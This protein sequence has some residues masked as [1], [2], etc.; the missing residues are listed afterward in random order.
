MKTVAILITVAA[1]LL[2]VGNLVAFYLKEI[3]GL[4]L[5]LNL[6]SSLCVFALGVLALRRHS[7]T[8]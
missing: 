2:I 8:D 3:D 1:S 6:M 7:A 5:T 4:T